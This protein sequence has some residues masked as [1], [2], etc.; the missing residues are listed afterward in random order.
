MRHQLIKMNIMN[1]IR[2]IDHKLK[3]QW[4]AIKGSKQLETLDEDCPARFLEGWTD[5][6]PSLWETDK[7]SQ[8]DILFANY[9]A[10]YKNKKDT[11]KI[12]Y[13]SF[14]KSTIDEA[15]LALIKTKGKT[16]DPLVDNFDIHHEI[17]GMTAKRL[18]VLIFHILKSQFE[19]GEY[20]K[21]DFLKSQDEFVKNYR[22]QLLSDALSVHPE[23]PSSSETKQGDNSV[24][25][26]ISTIYK[27]FSSGSIDPS[28]NESPST[29]AWS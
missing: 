21:G 7:L 8:E 24:Y 17:Q 12:A 26:E 23:F 22:T 28:T 29:T 9:N 2:I 5:D 11:D 18:C 25:E 1:L 4:D 20:K 27:P 19:T 15:Q 10:R 16:N 3:N 13:V 6:S 14:N